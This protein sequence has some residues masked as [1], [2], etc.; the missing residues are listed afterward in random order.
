MPVHSQ[1]VAVGCW[2]TSVAWLAES[3]P[4]CQEHLRKVRD[5]LSQRRLIPHWSK[6][7]PPPRP[8]VDESRPS[9][10]YY[11]QIGDRIKIG[12]T[13][14][15]TRRWYRLAGQYGSVT[16]LMAEPGGQALEFQRHAQ[17]VHHR[18]QATETFTP[19][20]PLIRHITTLVDKHPDW[21]ESVVIPAYQ[22]TPPKGRPKLAKSY[23]LEALR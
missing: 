16:I 1:C 19:A 14:A 10:V 5:D 9:L 20:E 12:T 7:K 18:I 6:R 2:V 21:W 22:A 23:T 8:V 3:I 15:P 13:V 4:V 11:A 17:F